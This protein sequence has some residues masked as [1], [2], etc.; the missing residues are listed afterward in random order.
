MLTEPALMEEVERTNAVVVRNFLQGQEG[1][2]RMRR[3]PN[4]MKV[5]KGR[6][7]YSYGGFGHIVQNCRN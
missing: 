4:A 3:D 5:D 6:N 1:R 7:C 2:E